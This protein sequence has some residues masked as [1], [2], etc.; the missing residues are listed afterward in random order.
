ME[1]GSDVTVGRCA[2]LARSALLCPGPRNSVQ[3]P[4]HRFLVPNEPMRT[5][6]AAIVCFAPNKLTHRALAA[7]VHARPRTTTCTFQ[8]VGRA[9]THRANFS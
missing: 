6:P 5:V 2:G 7:D 1:T 4:P 3:E 8:G 9:L